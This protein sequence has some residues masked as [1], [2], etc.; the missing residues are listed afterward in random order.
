MAGVDSIFLNLYGIIFEAPKSNHC[1]E[2]GL[3][4]YAMRFL[5]KLII[6]IAKWKHQGTWKSQIYMSW[7]HI[8][9]SV[10]FIIKIF[11]VCES[12]HSQLLALIIWIQILVHREIILYYIIICKYSTK[13]TAWNIWYINIC[14]PLVIF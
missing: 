3:Q 14:L 7:K 6:L 4:L 2:Q 12:H 13:N 8:N 11:D 5:T 1:E 10:G 9:S